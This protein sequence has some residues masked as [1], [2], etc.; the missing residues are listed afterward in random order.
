MSLVLSETPIELKSAIHA[1]EGLKR[2]FRIN[3]PQLSMRRLVR[4][5]L[6]VDS[7]FST[8]RGKE[9]TAL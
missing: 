3:A 7:C 1:A 5:D 6:L 4:R 8:L 2:H 9:G